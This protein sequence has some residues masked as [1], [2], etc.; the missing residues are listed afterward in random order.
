MHVAE[1]TYSVDHDIIDR[2]LD[3]ME[4]ETGFEPA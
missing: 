4:V 1:A 3:D 2:S